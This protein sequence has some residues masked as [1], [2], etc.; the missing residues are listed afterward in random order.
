MLG[1]RVER[2]GEIRVQLDGLLIIPKRVLPLRGSVFPLAGQIRLE[3]G[4]RRRRRPA[5]AGWRVLSIGRQDV[6]TQELQR[7]PIYQRRGTVG[8]PGHP[9]SAPHP[10]ALDVLHLSDELD[11]GTGPQR[12]PGH[13]VAAAQA[14]AHFPRL[15]R[16]QR[17]GGAPSHPPPSGEDGHGIDLPQ[18][19]E[20]VK[21]VREHVHDALV[22]QRRI[23]ARGA[24][25]Q[26]GDAGYRAGSGG[27][28]WTHA[29]QSREPR[30]RDRDS[31][32]RHSRDG[33]RGEHGPVSRDPPARL[34]LHPLGATGEPRAAHQSVTK[35]R[36][37]GEAVGRVAR[38]RHHDRLLHA[39]R[40][41]FADMADLR[42]R[43]VSRRAIDACAV[44]AAKGGWPASIS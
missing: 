8:R 32:Q 10:A 24:E 38:E 31:R 2:R 15:V 40:H 17:V 20:S 36:G 5:Q 18:L 16:C 30:Q 11:V 9:D 23:G 1:Q 42:R 3:R 26:D 43:L 39:S 27:D 19:P 22:P 13:D 6:A 44:G 29:A 37:R 12:L 41:A 34:R 28:R 7:Q 4:E 21:V 25:W 14:A 35:R 33:D